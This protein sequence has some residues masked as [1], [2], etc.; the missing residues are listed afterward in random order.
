VRDRREGV[1]RA[2]ES[3]FHEALHDAQRI[4]TAF[5]A[6][7][8]RLLAWRLVRFQCSCSAERVIRALLLASAGEPGTLFDPAQERLQVTCEYCKATYAIARDD[9]AAASH[10]PN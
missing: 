2:T 1:A 5:A 7:G 4:E 9:L 8:F 3:I 6:I 10:A